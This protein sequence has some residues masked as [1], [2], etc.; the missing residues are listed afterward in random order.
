MNNIYS[1]FINVDF[2]FINIRNNNDFSFIIS[3]FYKINSIIKYEIEE[4]YF[5]NLKSY[6]LIIKFASNKKFIFIEFTNLLN[7]KSILKKII[8]NFI[9]KI[10]LFNDI[11]IYEK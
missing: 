7:S 3:H 9:L 11:I 4:V 10:K 5:M 1:H 8:I 6:S 2:N